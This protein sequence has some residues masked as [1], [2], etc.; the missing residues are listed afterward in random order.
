M[1]VVLVNHSDSKGGASVVTMRLLNALVEIGVDARMLVM[2]KTTDS[3]RVEELRPEW[4]RQA[5]F[6]YEHACIFAR[7]GLSRPNLFKASIACCGMPLHKHPW[8][9]QADV[10][11]LNWVNQGMLSLREI[12]KIKAPVV[13]TMHDMWCMTG[14]CHHAGEC[15]RYAGECGHCPLLHSGTSMH[16]LSY[17]TLRRKQELYGKKKIHFIA[18]SHWL[19]DKCKE[20]ALLKSQDVRV[21]PNAFPTDT[22]SWLTEKEC[23]YYGLPEDKHLIVMGAARLDDPIKGLPLAIEALNKVGRDDVTAVFFGDIRNPEILNDLKIEYV[24]LGPLHDH[25]TIND[26]YAHASV[27]LSSSHYETLPGTLIE[28][29]AAGGVPV[30]FGQGGQSDIVDHMVNGYIARYPDTEDLARGIRWALESDLSLHQLRED[31]DR[32]F[33]ARPWPLPTKLCLKK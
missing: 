1:K 14:V 23:D 33:S 27:V 20:S 25:R 24:N 7:N 11:C 4:K 12:E 29:L 6:L 18:V 3:P 31:V 9:Q 32:K 26:I 15:L 16:D 13:W 10:V 19:A 21:I 5:C 17:S 22:F 30:T 8:I 28:G 2:H